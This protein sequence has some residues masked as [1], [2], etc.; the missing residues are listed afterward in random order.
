MILGKTSTT[1]Q[2]KGSPS[3]GVAGFWEEFKL[4]FEIDLGALIIINKLYALYYLVLVLL[5]QPF[6]SH[7]AD[8]VEFGIAYAPEVFHQVLSQTVD[9]PIDIFRLS[10]LPHIEQ[11]S[12][13]PLPVVHAGNF[14]LFPLLFIMDFVEDEPQSHI[15]LV[16]SDSVQ[17]SADLHLPIPLSNIPYKPHIDPM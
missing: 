17:S 8:I 14:V 6:G 4:L 16:R 7:L 13:N 5:D 10:H 2:E 1:T 15:M 3:V 9:Q 11:P 12:L